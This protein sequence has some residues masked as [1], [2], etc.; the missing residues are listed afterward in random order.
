MIPRYIGCVAAI[1][2][3]FCATAILQSCRQQTKDDLEKGLVNFEPIKRPLGDAEIYLNTTDSIYDADGNS[4][5]TITIGDQVWM[6]SNLRTTRCWDGSLLETIDIGNTS[7]DAAMYW[8]NNNDT[9][10]TA[11]EYGPMYNWATIEKCEVCPKNFKVP[12]QVEWRKLIRFW[13][14]K[15]GIPAG[16]PGLT[17]ASYKLREPGNRLW[18]QIYTYRDTIPAIGFNAKPGGW[19]E[20][21]QLQFYRERTGWWGRNGKLPVINKIADGDGGVW[22]IGATVK[23]SAYVRCVKYK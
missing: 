12:S 19:L 20:D 4:Y 16:D 7:K 13:Y 2:V 11:I 17:Y 15:N 14:G 8:L 21:G 1:L 22:V 18:S 23:H 3:L 6:T 9:G 10:D 5:T